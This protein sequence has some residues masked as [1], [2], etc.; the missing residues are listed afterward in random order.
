M[1]KV[2]K[3]YLVEVEDTSDDINFRDIDWNSEVHKQYREKAIENFNP[4]NRHYV[5]KTERPLK[6]PHY[7]FYEE[8]PF[9]FGMHSGDD[10]TLFAIEGIEQWGEVEGL[11]TRWKRK[12]NG[13]IKNE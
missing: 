6:D 12:G 11:V 13:R 2:E 5:G 4:K 10:R 8:G 7:S 3:Y 9:V 1:V